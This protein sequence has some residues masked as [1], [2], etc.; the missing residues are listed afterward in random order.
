MSMTDRSAFAAA[1]RQSDEQLDLALAALLLA[2]IHAPVEQ[3]ERYQRLLDD[4]AAWLR[5]RLD[6]DDDPEHTMRRLSHYLA[7]DRGFHGNTRDYYDPRN[8]CLNAVLD[9]R[10]GI[11]ITL[12]V[13]YLEVGWRLGLPLAGVGLPG[14]FLVKYAG[15]GREIIVDPFNGGAILSRDD[16][17]ARLRQVYGR[18]VALEAHYLAAVTRKQILMRMLTNLKHIYLSPPAPDY[19][20]ALDAIEHLLVLSPWALD[21]IR[22]RGLV[23]WQLGDTE[24]AIA[25]L[26]TYLT[27]AGDA[28]DAPLVRQRL[29]SLR[30]RPAPGG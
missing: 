1:V 18:P 13:V 26:E 5:L 25:D 10:T 3:P 15:Q 19:A 12:S 22:D 24:R 9:R 29:A 8:S 21:Q 17:A 11:P 6:P 20:R 30:R 4:D 16:C 27:Y 2:R 23:R 28:E 14:H 7:V